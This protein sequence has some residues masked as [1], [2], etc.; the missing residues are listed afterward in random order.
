MFGLLFKGE[1]ANL[2]KYIIIHH[3]H[4]VRKY[5]NLKGKMRRSKLCSNFWDVDYKFYY[6][7][8]LKLCNCQGFIIHNF[9]YYNALVEGY[10]KPIDSKNYNFLLGFII[11]CEVKYTFVLYKS[12][13]EVVKLPTKI[14]MHIIYF[15]ISN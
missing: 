13:V 14:T 2:P 4:K 7:H 10:K 11:Q 3:C 8:M 9:S 6:N 15:N 12:I 5:Q 1:D